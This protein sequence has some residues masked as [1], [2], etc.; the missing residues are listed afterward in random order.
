MEPRKLVIRRA[1][2]GRVAVYHGRVAAAVFF[3]L[4]VRRGGFSGSKNRYTAQLLKDDAG[5]CG[6]LVILFT[7]HPGM[8]NVSYT[9]LNI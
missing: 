3:S 5:T 1:G 2:V 7:M 8:D 6:S 4:A 9:N